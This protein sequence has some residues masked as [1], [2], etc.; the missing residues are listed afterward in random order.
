MASAK[1]SIWNIDSQD[2][3]HGLR[4]HGPDCAFPFF[5]NGYGVRPMYALARRD[6][7]SSSVRPQPKNKES[8]T[9]ASRRRQR[10]G[11]IAGRSAD[12]RCW[13]GAPRARESMDKEEERVKSMLFCANPLCWQSTP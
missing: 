12:Q 4:A 3:L 10:V 8:A 13:V 2:G 5:A 7:P 11:L 1:A 9:V 6:R